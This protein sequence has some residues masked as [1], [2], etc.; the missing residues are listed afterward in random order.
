CAQDSSAGICHHQ[1][2]APRAPT[3]SLAGRL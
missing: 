1:S 2:P 3:V